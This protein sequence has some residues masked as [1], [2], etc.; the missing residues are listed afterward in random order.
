MLGLP[1]EEANFRFRLPSPRATRCLQ[2]DCLQ[3]DARME[4]EL[5]DHIYQRIFSQV[6]SLHAV[7]SYQSAVNYADYKRLQPETQALLVLRSPY[8]AYRLYIQ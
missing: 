2:S 4:L 5:R 6:A 3:S 1:L 8:L 7:N